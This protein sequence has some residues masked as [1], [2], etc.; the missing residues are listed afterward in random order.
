MMQMFENWEIHSL[1]VSFLLEMERNTE[2]QFRS[3]SSDGG[4]D[5]ARFRWILKALGRD[6]AEIQW[7]T[8]Q[9]VSFF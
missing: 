6:G 9:T 7:G 5:P 2:I 3:Q 8:W 4:C 1:G